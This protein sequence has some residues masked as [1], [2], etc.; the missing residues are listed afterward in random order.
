MVEHAETF[1]S[2]YA[3]D[4]DAALEVQPPDSWDSFPLFQLIND[5]LR[6]DC[7]NSKYSGQFETILFF[8]LGWNEWYKD[9]VV[10]KCQS[11]FSCNF[12][13]LMLVRQGT[14]VQL[15]IKSFA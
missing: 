12:I 8:Y 10:E 9:K 14:S 13:W 11:R 3:V 4:M 15:R 7:K 2:L 6:L 1:L 5:Y